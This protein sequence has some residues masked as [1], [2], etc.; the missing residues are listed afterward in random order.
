M[1]RKT[2]PDGDRSAGE[3]DATAHESLPDKRVLGEQVQQAIDHTSLDENLGALPP[4]LRIDPTELFTQALQQTRM[5][6]CVSDP[7][8][9]DEPIVF[10]NEAFVRLTGYRRDEIIGRNCRFLQGEASDPAAVRA[11]RDAIESEEVTVVDVLNYRKDGTPFWNAVHIGPIFGENGE[12]EYLYGSQWDVTEM[13]SQREEAVRQKQLAAEMRHRTGN[14]FAVIS[15]IVRI[16]ARGEDDVPTVVGKVEERLAALGRAHRMTAAPE[17]GEAAGPGAETLSMLIDEVLKPYRT[18]RQHRIEAAG[19]RLSLSREV[20]TPL[21]LT[22]HELATNA[23]KHGSLSMAAGEVNIEWKWV[24]DRVHIVWSELNGPS[25]ADPPAAPAVGSGA[26]MR[27]TR[28]MLQG[29][30]ATLDLDFRSNGLRATVDLPG[31]LFG[32]A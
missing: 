22:L 25:A 8:Q 10:C 12:L 14:L 3:G 28:G 5:A 11:M 9:P 20:L 21:G 17:D 4:R 7:R 24:A 15:A 13:V 1:D 19:P 16:S 18:Q 23:I 6:L 31:R 30:E 2:E 26:G 27:I 29:V 32:P